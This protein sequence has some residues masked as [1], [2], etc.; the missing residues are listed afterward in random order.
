MPNHV[1]NDLYVTGPE[2]AL[3]AFVEFARGQEPDGLGGMKEA[4]LSAEK[5]VPIPADLMR[6]HYICDRCGYDK[7]GAPDGISW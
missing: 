3:K 4:L 5:F 7:E 1:E 6:G 2:E